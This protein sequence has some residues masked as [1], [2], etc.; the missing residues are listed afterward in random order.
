MIEYWNAKVKLINQLNQDEQYESV[1]VIDDDPIVC[2]M[3]E[4]LHIEVY[5]AEMLKHIPKQIITV[6]FRPV[7]NDAM[8]DLITM[9]RNQKVRS[10]KPVQTTM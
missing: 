6:R 9:F 8:S 1:I 2:M 3:A 7:P 5:E 4:R 10:K